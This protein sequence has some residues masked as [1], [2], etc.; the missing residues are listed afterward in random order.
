MYGYVG[1]D[2]EGFYWI[3]IYVQRGFNDEKIVYLSVPVISLAVVIR[4]YQ[5][6]FSVSEVSN[7]MG[8]GVPKYGL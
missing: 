8:R 4:R 2:N 1:R 5:F 3:H 6:V 7:M